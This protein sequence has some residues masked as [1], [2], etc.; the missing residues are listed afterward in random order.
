VIVVKY[1]EV[2]HT[3]IGSKRV[4]D[5]EFKTYNDAKKD[6]LRVDPERIY[7]IAMAAYETYETVKKLENL[8]TENND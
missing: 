4:T 5:E 6:A 1:G 7:V 2:F 8:N 3:V